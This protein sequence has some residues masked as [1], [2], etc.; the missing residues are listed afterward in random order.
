VVDDAA[1]LIAAH[2]RDLVSCRQL[3]QRCPRCPW[4]R[5]THGSDSVGSGF[6]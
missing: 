2:I 4:V 6:L 1:K 3:S 5:T